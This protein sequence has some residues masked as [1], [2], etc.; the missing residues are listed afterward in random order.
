MKEKD[1]ISIIVPC[2][3]VEKYV[4]KTIETIVNQTYSNIEVVVVE[5]C[6]K[7]NTY[8]IL[9]KLQKKYS[10]KMKLFQNKENGG[11][12]YTR[13]RGLEYATGDY[14]G[15][16][17]SDDFIDPNYFEELM[18]AIKKEDADIAITDIVLANENGE[19]IGQPQRGCNGEVTKLNVISTGMAASSCNKLFKRE[20]IEKYP[21][22]EGKIN[23]DVSAIIPAIINAK[24]I[25]YTDKVV[26]YYV[27]RNTSIQNSTFSEKRYDMFDAIKICLQ[28]IEGCKDFDKYREAILYHQLLMLYVYVIIEQDGYKNRYNLIKKFI[29]KQQDFK[30]YNIKLFKEFLNTQG[31][32]SRIYYSTLVRLIKYKA[33]FLIN[34]I[35]SMKKGYK[36]VV[37][38]IKERLKILLKITVI[39]QDLT[40]KD[41]IRMAKKQNKLK[42]ND[43]KV[44]V[45][46]PNYNYEKFMIQR[47]YSI[48]SQTEKIFE[49]I[50][51]DDCSKDNSRALIDEIVKVISDYIPVKKIYN[52]KNSGI[53]FKQWA[54]GFKL[55]KGDY[56][57]IAEADD[58]CNK[59]LLENLLKPI[60]QNKDKDIYLSYA[61]TAFI[62]AWAKVFL[63]SIKPEIDLRK[64]GHWDS[65]FINKGED[66]VKTYSFLNCT[67][68]NVSSCI[69]KNDNYNEIFDKIIEYRQAGDWLFYV[70]VIKRGY[71]SYV[72]KP[73]NYYRV[74]GEN[75]TSTMKKQKHLEEIKRIHKDIKENFE[76]NEWHDEQ[77]QK[78]Y[79]FLTKAWQLDKEE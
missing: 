70:N 74:H 31:K 23:E 50:I 49:I 29:E 7:D 10:D 44:S 9:K 56:V 18:K 37:R 73:L 22:L 14:I 13:N 68:A 71:I 40:I 27:Q 55:A 47:L 24:K 53:A 15:Y 45:V 48:L 42:E 54:K 41:L 5:D 26:Y 65:D 59:K 25:A 78:R 1:L 16:I 28:R 63:P 11:L 51:L 72:N 32:L 34:L 35:I 69:I 17:D 43:I 36:N 8:K 62:N 77:M 75:I 61:D 4:E 38:F 12:A 20:I 67:V 6:S 52:E 64:T 33:T 58:C 79:E 21:F 46:V 3:N 2:Y 19:K 76:L 39:R 60:R 66:E 57:W 30:V